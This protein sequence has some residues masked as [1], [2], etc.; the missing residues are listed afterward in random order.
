MTKILL[1][2]DGSAYSQVCCEYGSWILARLEKGSLDI[3]YVSNRSDQASFDRNFDLARAYREIISFMT[4]HSIERAAPPM[5]ITRGALSG[6]RELIAAIPVILGDDALSG[7]VR[8]GRSPAGLALRVTHH[9]PYQQLEASYSMASA[10]IAAHG[11]REEPVSWEHYLSDP[12]ATPPD[13][14]LTHIYLRIADAR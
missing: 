3:L 10:W 13:D 7:R 11:Y 8:R 6:Q 12:G 14:L 4:L 1:C 2:S 9:G 5:T